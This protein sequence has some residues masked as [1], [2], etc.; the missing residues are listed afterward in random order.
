MMMM[1]LKRNAVQADAKMNGKPKPAKKTVSFR[2]DV[3]GDSS[4]TEIDQKSNT[5]NAVPQIKDSLL[6]I[7]IHNILILGSM[8]YF[9]ITQ[10]IEGVLL[11]SFVT[12]L[13]IQ[14]VYDYILIQS[15]KKRPK[16]DNVPLL[17]VSSL[18]VSLVLSVPMFLSIVILGAPVFGYT[19]K[20]FLLSLHLSQLV[21][22]PL[23]VLYSLDFE[24]FKKL[25]EYEDIYY[26]IFSHPILS[27]VLLTLGGCWLGVIPIP[28][29]WDR[30]WQQWPITLLG[31][32]YVGGVVGGLVSLLMRTYRK[33]N[34]SSS[35]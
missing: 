18:L 34:K 15:L 19:F 10:N 4:S 28:L 25:F 16:G 11:R 17:I 21:F 7:P 30:P 13:P 27:Q 1:T 6:L 31:G 24:K 2:H 22:G 29:D 12:S 35:E 33:W 9:G 20:T 26:T 14:A 3:N 8:F 23:T 32:S 5:Q